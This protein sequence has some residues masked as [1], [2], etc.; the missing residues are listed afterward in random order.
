MHNI[1]TILNIRFENHMNEKASIFQLNAILGGSKIV[2]TK[3]E[4]C[5][6]VDRIHILSNGLCHMQLKIPLIHFILLL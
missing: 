5:Q 3:W 4:V 1:F 6:L 2:Y